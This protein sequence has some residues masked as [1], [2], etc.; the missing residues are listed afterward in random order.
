MNKP[1][2]FAFLILFALFS[3][4][5]EKTLPDEQKFCWDC[6]SYVTAIDTLHHYSSQSHFETDTICGKTAEE[7]NLSVVDGNVLHKEENFKD[8]FLLSPGKIYVVFRIY[9]TDCKKM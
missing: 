7:M 1:I 5:K 4:K 8:T 9:V 6:I 3:C 2:I